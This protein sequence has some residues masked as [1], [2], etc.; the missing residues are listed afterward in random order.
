MHNRYRDSAGELSGGGKNSRTFFQF[1]NG[2][3]KYSEEHIREIARSLPGYSEDEVR[4]SIKRAHDAMRNEKIKWPP[5][6][7]EFVDTYY[8][9]D[10]HEV[11]EDVR[12]QSTDTGADVEY[13]VTDCPDPEPMSVSE[14]DLFFFKPQPFSLYLDVSFL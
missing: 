9:P 2:D 6:M 11:P 12:E 1:I 4:S 13:F 8:G 14:M 10:G 5:A 7:T 3:Y